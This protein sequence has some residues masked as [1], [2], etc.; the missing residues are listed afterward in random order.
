MKI[1]GKGT[2]LAWDIFVRKSKVTT[3]GRNILSAPHNL[4]FLSRWWWQIFFLNKTLCCKIFVVT[5]Q[6]YFRTGCFKSFIFLQSEDKTSQWSS[7]NRVCCKKWVFFGTD[8]NFSLGYAAH[9]HGKGTNCFAT[10]S[11]SGETY[12]LHSG[13]LK[14][15][16]EQISPEVIIGGEDN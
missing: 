10:R 1:L 5:T 7:H 12:I 3:D 2:R 14:T 11:Q 9:L 13:M 8:G 15:L 4:C 16:P 6:L